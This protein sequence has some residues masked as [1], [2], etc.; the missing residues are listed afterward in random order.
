MRDPASWAVVDKLRDLGAP[1]GRSPLQMALGWLLSRP[2]I[3]SPIIG[4][5]SLL[6][7]EENLGAV[8]LRLDEAERKALD[9]VSAW[10]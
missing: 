5:R 3:T 4:P 2:S 7:L 9:E 1:R 10:S 6:Q 8:G